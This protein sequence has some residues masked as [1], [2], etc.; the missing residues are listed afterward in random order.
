MQIDSI[1][2]KFKEANLQRNQLS[3]ISHD[4]LDKINYMDYNIRK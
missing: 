3:G 1:E 4:L 2:N